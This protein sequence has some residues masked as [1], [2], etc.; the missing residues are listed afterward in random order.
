[1]SDAKIIQFPSSGREEAELDVRRWQLPTSVRT[2][3]R[4]GLEGPEVLQ[5]LSLV[6]HDRERR[7]RPGTTRM[8]ERTTPA[9][10]AAVR[11]WTRAILVSLHGF[12]G[13]CRERWPDVTAD[14]EWCLSQVGLTPADVEVTPEH[15]ARVWTTAPALLG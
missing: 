11:E 14:C 13:D 10:R 3:R 9:T 8:T 6:F 4:A 7:R 1:M 5:Q 2:L 12:A 15:V